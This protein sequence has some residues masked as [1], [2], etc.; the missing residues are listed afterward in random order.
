MDEEK[1]S[2]VSL[3]GLIVGPMLYFA[4]LLGPRIEGLS[5]AGQAVLAA[6]ALMATFWLTEAIPLSVTALLPIVLFP[7]TGVLSQREVTAAY[8]SDIFFLF[9]GGFLLSIAIQ[10]WNLHHRISL[11][12]I[13]I[14]GVKPSRIVL[15]FMVATAFLSMWI[16]NTAAAILMVSIA[17]P[18]I[19]EFV[20]LAKKQ[21]LD[22]DTEPGHFNFGSA[23][24]LG[25]GYA[26]TVGGMA[27][28][29]GTVPN[30]IFAGTVKTV[31]DRE[32]TFIEWMGVGLPLAVIGIF[33]ARLYLTR[34]AF[35]LQKIRF[36]QAGEL[37]NSKLKH[38]GKLKNEE[39]K[40]LFVF[41]FMAGMWI[42]RGFLEPTLI[43]LGITGVTDATISIAGAIM[44]FLIPIDLKKGKFILSRDDVLKV[45]WNILILFSGG[46]ALAKGIEVSGLAQWIASN[47]GFLAGFHNLVVLLVIVGLVVFLTEVMSN[48]AIAIIF[49]PVMANLGPTIGINPL[50]LM[51]GVAL[52]A[53]SAFMLP[54]AT[55]PNAVVYGTR[56]IRVKQMIR[57]GIWM[58]VVFTLLSVLVT[59]FWLP[60]VIK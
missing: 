26:A 51:F 10:K 9:L 3:T 49:L 7:I 44:L 12:I 46:L 60:V 38:L 54:V 28:L 31:L 15:G 59:Y 33:I 21:K 4:I 32:I 5:P 2:L 25:V 20:Q 14:F 50:V 47:L 30:S 1:Y 48:T 19:T 39:I 11:N 42:L 27:T 53:S 36:H 13:R 45:P 55:P 6:T 43:R 52:A 56:Y 40:V 8:G 37:I 16:S 23:L 18:V 35:P 17:L 58:N 34:I 29:I 22:I 57:T 41:C 24:M